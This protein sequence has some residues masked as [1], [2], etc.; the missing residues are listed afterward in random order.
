M[1]MS[2]VQPPLS[3]RYAFLVVS[4]VHAIVATVLTR[5]DDVRNIHLYPSQILHTLGTFLFQPRDLMRL[6]SLNKQ[7]FHTI[8]PQALL[9]RPTPTGCLLT[10]AN[11][12]SRMYRVQFH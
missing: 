4:H 10:R 12:A 9:P 11:G 1:S 8:Y 3:N 7:F 2:S 6:R 5:I